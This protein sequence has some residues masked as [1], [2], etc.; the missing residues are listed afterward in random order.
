MDKSVDL[1]QLRLTSL[2]LAVVLTGLVVRPLPGST[3]ADGDFSTSCRPLPAGSL[4][5]SSFVFAP[6]RDK[7]ETSA[8][9]LVAVLLRETHLHPNRKELDG[10][11]GVCQ[12]SSNGVAVTQDGTRAPPSVLLSA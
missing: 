1:C 10:L 2:I 3:P 11:V 6:D 5:L 4:A 12:G 9:Q 8:T 7:H